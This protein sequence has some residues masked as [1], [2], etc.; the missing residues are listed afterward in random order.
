MTSTYTRL[1]KAFIDGKSTT[2]YT[3]ERSHR[4]VTERT[5]D[6]W[7]GVVVV[8]DSRYTPLWMRD[9][10]TMDDETIVHD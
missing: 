1:Y 6:A 8:C 9:R 5:M 4:G 7:G 3:R 10:D 2:M